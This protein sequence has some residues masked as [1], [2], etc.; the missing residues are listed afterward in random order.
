M[1]EERGF[2]TVDIAGSPWRSLTIA[3]ADLGNPR[4]QILSSLAPV[5]ERVDRIRRLV[6]L[7][8]LFA[9]ALTA[10]AAWGLTTLAVR[11]LARL[12]GGAARVRGAEDLSTPLADDRA[13]PDEVASSR[14][15][16]TR[17]SP[18]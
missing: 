9:L 11:P 16:S 10:L 12:R 17:C 7:L 1:P 14:A 5:E 8:G 4:L 3:V 6:L 13:A 2:D 15:R 18:A